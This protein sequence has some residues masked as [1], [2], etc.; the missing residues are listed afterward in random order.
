VSSTSLPRFGHAEQGNLRRSKT[1]IRHG[2][3]EGEGPQLQLPPAQTRSLTAPGSPHSTDDGWHSN[4]GWGDS[5]SEQCMVALD[6]NEHIN[7]FLGLEASR[8][9]VCFQKP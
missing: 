2:P 5:A 1:S 3:V 7:A 4:G 8:A 9:D 6:S